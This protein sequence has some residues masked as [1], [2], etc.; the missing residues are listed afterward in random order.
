MG[1]RDDARRDFELRQRQRLTNE[2]RDEDW[3][4]HDL[5]I[6][7]LQG[8]LGKYA[9]VLWNH[10][11][12][13]VRS[14][15]RTPEQDEDLRR[16]EVPFDWLERSA[17]VTIPD[18]DGLEFLAVL[19]EA[20]EGTFEFYVLGDCDLCGRYVPLVPALDGG[21]LGKVLTANV[22]HEHRCPGR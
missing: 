2:W 18:D 20:D 10:P 21:N 4:H 1:V 22:P 11:G 3:E 15:S 7:G 8:C 5:Y 12:L 13:Q 6:D 14:P 17:V 9:E 16:P 19:D